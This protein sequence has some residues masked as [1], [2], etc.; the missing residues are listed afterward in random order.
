[1]YSQKKGSGLLDLY[2]RI[3]C[4]FPIF[5]VLRNEGVQN[6]ILLVA[7]VAVH[8][9]I[10]CK[11]KVKKNTVMVFIISLGVYVYTLFQ[12]TF[13]LENINTLFYFLITILYM[14]LCSDFQDGI[15]T[16]LYQNEKYVRGIIIIWTCIVGVSFFS[17]ISYYVKEG[18]VRYFGSFVGTIFRLGPTA[19]FIQILILV[20]MSYYDR[21]NDI[22]FMIL[23]IACFLLGSSRTY[24]VIGVCLFVIAWYWYGVRTSNFWLTIIPI[25]MISLSFIMQTPLGMKILYTLDDSNYG[26][27][28]YRVTS[29]RSL[30]WAKDIEAW[31]LESMANKLFGSGIE[32]TM[33]QTGLWAHNDFIELLCSV[34]I[35]GV[36]VYVM[37][38]LQMIGS[39][40]KGC[41]APK[42]VVFSIVL[43]WLFNAFFNMHYTYFCSMLSYPL[44]LMA[45]RHY[46]ARKKRE[47]EV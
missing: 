18:G 33:I 28:W 29:S 43:T 4:L 46:Y 25:A 16:W 19:M 3:V 38:M 11:N 24:L 23:P 36:T 12:T 6:K 41:A 1:M 40:L 32:F 5:T 45:I 22:Y 31:Q 8:L 42:I 9:L 37:I 35:V 34:G 17:P 13:P 7:L 26:D 27:F 10:L 14:R 15:D 20:S 21:K 30:F 47:N 2:F 39:N 44:G